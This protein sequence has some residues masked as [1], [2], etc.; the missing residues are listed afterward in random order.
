MAPDENGLLTRMKTVATRLPQRLSNP[1]PNDTSHL[2]MSS[3]DSRYQYPRAASLDLFDLALG[4]E[5]SPIMPLPY[6]A[7]KGLERSQM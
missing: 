3:G 5:D 1:N 2:M 4:G 6:S 7:S